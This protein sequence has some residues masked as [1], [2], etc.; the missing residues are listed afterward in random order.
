MEKDDGN[1]FVVVALF[2]NYFF[3]E[4]PVRRKSKISFTFNP[5]ES[6]S[7]F[8]EAITEGLRLLKQFFD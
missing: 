7:E 2:D 8:S 5:S 6:V 1:W 3:N 4:E